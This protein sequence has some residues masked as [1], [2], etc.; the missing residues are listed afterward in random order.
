M[1]ANSLTILSTSSIIIGGVKLQSGERN[2]KSKSF[3]RSRTVF[4]NGSYYSFP[5]HNEYYPLELAVAQ[6][7]MFSKSDLV[8]FLDSK[9]EF[10]IGVFIRDNRNTIAIEKHNFIT[11]LRRYKEAMGK[12]IIVNSV[13]DDLDISS[14]DN[15]DYIALERL[16]DLIDPNKKKIVLIK[17]SLFAMLFIMTII[18]FN[19]FND[20]LTHSLSINQQN[21]QNEIQT[22]QKLMK[23]IN[24][25]PSL[26]NEKIR[27]I[28]L[29]KILNEIEVG[30][31]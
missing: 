22:T 29:E 19:F 28:Q 30:A 15:I 26:P 14:M 31:K 5:K 27:T 13:L 7:D 25:N 20:D 11:H 9:S 4:Y 21:L 23:E 16:P 6:I 1:N 3:S 18:I 12:I 17:Y 2:K 10:Y 8:F 24:I